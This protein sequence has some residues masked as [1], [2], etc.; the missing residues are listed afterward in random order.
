LTKLRNSGTTTMTTTTTT[1]PL[2]DLDLLLERLDQEYAWQYPEQETDGTNEDGDDD[3]GKRGEANSLST[4]WFEHRDVLEPIFTKLV[5][6][7]IV[8]ES[9]VTRHHPG[10]DRHGQPVTTSYRPLDAVARF[11]LGNGAQFFRINV[12]ANL[13]EEEEEEEN[14]PPT[15][16]NVKP[17]YHDSPESSVSSRRIHHRSPGSSH[18]SWQ[19][20][21]GIMVNYRYN[22]SWLPQNQ[23]HYKDRE[24]RSSTTDGQGEAKGLIPV[25]RHIVPWI[26]SQLAPM[27][28]WEQSP[29]STTP[30]GTTGYHN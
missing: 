28:I 24:R 8:F 26:P 3:D 17:Y 5:A 1:T 11:H 29:T 10:T 16:H 7:Y 15:P 20:S 22:L 25:S 27:A 2:E 18:L 6:R 9:Q 12:A 13:M 19:Q 4:F 21:W 23:Q 14:S 30:S